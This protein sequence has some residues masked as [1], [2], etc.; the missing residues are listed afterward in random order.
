MLIP[1]PTCVRFSRPAPVGRHGGHLLPLTMA[2]K[3]EL[4][5][6]VQMFCST[7]EH[8]SA[9]KIPRNGAVECKYYKGCRSVPAGGVP[10]CPPPAVCK[11]TFLLQP[12]PLWLSHSFVFPISQVSVG[13]PS[14]SNFPSLSPSLPP[15]LPLPPPFCCCS[16]QLGIFHIFKSLCI[17]CELFCSLPIF[18]YFFGLCHVD[19]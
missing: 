7:S 11:S 17:V 14:I 1:L 9:G 15:S 4:S 6:L 13:L 3:T 16:V 12:V 8:R 2:H 5:I 19:L 18:L 10:S